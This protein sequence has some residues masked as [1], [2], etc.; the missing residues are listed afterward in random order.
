MEYLYFSGL[1]WIFGF[2]TIEKASIVFQYIFTILN[3]LQGFIIFI[4]FTA[5]EKRVRQNWQKLCCKRTTKEKYLQSDTNTDRNR[6][7][8]RILTS[9]TNDDTKFSGEDQNTSSCI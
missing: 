2:F 6:S 5:R 3:V 9:S 1:T 4:L 7:K 8:D